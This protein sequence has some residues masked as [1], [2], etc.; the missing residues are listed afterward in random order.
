MQMARPS[1]SARRCPASRPLTNAG[2]AACKLFSCWSDTLSAADRLLDRLGLP[3]SDDT[4]LRPLKQETRGPAA[5]EARVIGIDD[6]AQSKGQSY[7]TLVVDL[8][9]HRVVDLLAERS[10]EAIAAWLTAHPAIEVM[11]RDRNGR[12]AQAARRAAPQAT[13]VA[14][15]FPLV[16]NFREAVEREL[17]LPREHLAV[18]LTTAPLPL[19][20]PP[21][22]A[23][24]RVENKAERSSLRLRFGSG[25]VRSKDKV[26]STN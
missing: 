13:Q 4:I 16:Q 25:M 8:E 1:S 18:T 10:T 5:A 26:G 17:S 19:P 22:G 24:R 23:E 15:R 21:S 14:D 2:P 12:Y 20:P 3:A 7:G 6:G 11:A 9:N